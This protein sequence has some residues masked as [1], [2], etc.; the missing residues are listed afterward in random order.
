MK[1]RVIGLDLAKNE[2]PDIARALFANLLEYLRNLNV[3]IE[4]F[5]HEI[6]IWHRT[7]ETSQRLAAIPGI[8]PL[9][10]SAL[11]AATGD[12]TAFRNGRQFAAWLGLTPREHSSG[13]R[14]QLL[15]ISKRGDTYLRTL[16]IHGARAAINGHGRKTTTSVAWMDALLQRRHKNVATVALANKNARVVWALLAHDRKYQAGYAARAA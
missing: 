3:H 1:V 11:V 5:E 4:R 8:G 16:L 10:A 6:L 14:I 7:H 2:L 13:G 15:G 9:T 12:A